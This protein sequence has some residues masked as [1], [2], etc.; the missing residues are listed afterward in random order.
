MR[1]SILPIG[2]LLCVAVSS[3]GQDIPPD[4]ARKQLVEALGGPFVVYRDKVLEELKIS[5]DQ[6]QTLMEKF[7]EHVE[8]T[9]KVFDKIKDLKPNERDKEMQKHRKA[10]DEKL[11][12]ALKEVLDDKQRTRLFQIQLQQAGPFALLGEHELFVPMKMTAEQRKQFEEVV[13]DMQKK[14]EPLA[15]EAQSGGNPEEIRP[16]AMKIRQEHSEKIV[17]QLTKDQKEKWKEILG[18]PFEL[19]D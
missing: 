13:R 17:A 14:I 10:S 1:T 19:G 7:R 18:K 2:L 15:K 12:A 6:K 9:S 8:A 3:R 5:D 11:S 16:K 4:E